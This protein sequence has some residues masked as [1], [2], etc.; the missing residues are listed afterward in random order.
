MPELSYMIHVIVIAVACSAAAMTITKA[1]IFEYLREWVAARNQWLGK[2]V[3]C[4]Y[5]TS[6]WLAAAGA[7][8]IDP[9][10]HSF[11]IH[12]VV[13]S[14][15]IVAVSAPICRLIGWA[16]YHRDFKGEIAALETQNSQL[17]ENLVKS[18]SVIM[19]QQKLLLERSE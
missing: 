19:E 13:T 14:F 16:M 9:L 7:L 17:R 2:L 15:V 5:C 18:R 8:T 12:M 4:P 6:H 10:S 11:T 1:S 3:S